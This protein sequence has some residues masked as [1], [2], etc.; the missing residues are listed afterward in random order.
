MSASYRRRP[1]TAVEVLGKTSLL[2][3]WLDL[4]KFG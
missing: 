3:L 4:A 1:A 2:D